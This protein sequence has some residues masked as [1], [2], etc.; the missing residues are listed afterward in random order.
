MGARRRSSRARK[1]PSVEEHSQ[2]QKAN[3]DLARRWN[4]GIPSWNNSE[5]LLEALFALS[6]VQR[7]RRADG[8]LSSSE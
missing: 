4:V 1:P 6:R 3:F 8:S 7:E 5:G 2:G